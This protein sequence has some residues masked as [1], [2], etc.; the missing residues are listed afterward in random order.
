MEFR[1]QLS[2]KLRPHP[3]DH[4]GKYNQWIESQKN[5]DVSL[6]DSLTLAEAI[7]WS[8]VVVGCQTYAMVVALASGR[9]V[10]CSIPPRVATCVLPQ[11]EIVKLAELYADNSC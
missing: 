7:A 11:T 10:I 5:L 4:I 2:I 9:Q 1:E 3:S 6:D 8:N